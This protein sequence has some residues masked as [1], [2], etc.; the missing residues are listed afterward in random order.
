MASAQ[1]IMQRMREIQ[2]TRE[3][4]FE[5]LMKVLVER[6][7]LQQRLAELDEPY[8]QAFAA[9]EAA[10]WTKDELKALGAEEPTKRPKGRPRTRRATARKTASAAPSPTSPEAPVPAQ[11]HV[12]ET[13]VTS[14]SVSG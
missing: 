7:E 12:G 3:A 8:G 6:Q 9:A 2:A 11:N 13:A 4:A 10:G 1:E 5:P 14:G